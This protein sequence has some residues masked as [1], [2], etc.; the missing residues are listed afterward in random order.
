VA[1]EE[2]YLKKLP[3]HRVKTTLNGDKSC[4]KLNYFSCAVNSALAGLKKLDQVK[5]MLGNIEKVINGLRGGKQ[6]R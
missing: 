6:S 2:K 3:I 1:I 4:I 5:G